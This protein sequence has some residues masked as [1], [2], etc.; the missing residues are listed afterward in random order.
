VGVSVRVAD[1]GAEPA[2]GTI[3]SH[4]AFG[5]AAVLHVSVPLPVFVTF[6]VVLRVAVVP[7][8]AESVTEF[9]LTASTGR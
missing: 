9:G 5:D 2:L 4:D 1:P 7:T 6:N 8:F 3:E